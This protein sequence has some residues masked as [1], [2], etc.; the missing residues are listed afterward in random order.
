MLLQED[1]RSRVAYVFFYGTT[2][3]NLHILHYSYFL[4]KLSLFFKYTYM[5]GIS[6]FPPVRNYKKSLLLQNKTHGLFI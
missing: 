5:H 4:C 3:G 6:L 2:S 1:T